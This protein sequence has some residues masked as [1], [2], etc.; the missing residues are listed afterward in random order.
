MRAIVAATDIEDDDC[1][2]TYAKATGGASTVRN[3]LGEPFYKVVNR[4]VDRVR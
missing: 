1:E 3:E 4:A 2:G